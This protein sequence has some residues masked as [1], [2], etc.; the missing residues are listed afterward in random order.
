M[1][2]YFFDTENGDK[3]VDGEGV[4]L[5]S[6]EAAQMEAVLLMGDLIRDR[7]GEIWATG[8]LRL[9]VRDEDRRP[10][11][12]IETRIEADPYSLLALRRDATA[13]LAGWRS[14]PRLK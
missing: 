9:V 8:S 12:A 5:A 14:A 13:P 1:T 4:D 11:F 7:E 2:H 6:F 10:L 3:I